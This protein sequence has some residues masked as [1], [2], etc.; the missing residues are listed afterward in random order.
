MANRRRF[1]PKSRAQN[2]RLIERIFDKF[3]GGLCTDTFRV[4]DKS[5]GKL[6]NARDHKTE[7]RGRQGSFLHNNADFAL[8]NITTVINAFASGGD[9]E[10]S[11]TGD[12]FIV[13][14]YQDFDN[15]EMQGAIYNKEPH[16]K[17][18]LSAYDM[19]EVTDRATNEFKYLGNISV[20]K[21]WYPIVRDETIV[22]HKVG[23][24]VVKTSGKAFTANLKGCYWNW[25]YREGT[26]VYEPVRD[27]IEEVIDEN[28]LKIRSVTERGDENYVNCFV[29]GVIYASYYHQ[30]KNRVVMQVEDRLY[31]GMI[32][33]NGWS[34]IYGIYQQ[35]PMWSEGLFHEVKEDLLLS[36]SNG[37]F[38]IRFDSTG[39]HY[40]QINTPAPEQ[41]DLMPIK[42]F[43]F[44]SSKIDDAKFPYEVVGFHGYNSSGIRAG[45]KYFFD[46]RI[47]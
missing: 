20:P 31:E 21:M 25:G 19:F 30:A 39:T 37:H 3:G 13:Y 2:N 7:I 18:L 22:A 23:D 24:T 17:P 6:Y 38:R 45:N 16:K 44:Q 8:L 34:E 27:F 47:L 15:K 12:T 1:A 36:S 29:Q 9:L 11:V 42:I 5:L 28:T 14:S 35:R 40:W 4:P 32:P 41:P 26:T 10:T 33:L 43:G 46:G